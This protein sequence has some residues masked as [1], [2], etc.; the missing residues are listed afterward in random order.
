MENLIADLCEANNIVIILGF[1]VIIFRQ[2]K[3]VNIS[4]F[5]CL[6]SIR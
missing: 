5:I 2:M 6:I 1:G 3:K 4:S